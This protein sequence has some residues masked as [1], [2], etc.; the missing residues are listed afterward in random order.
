MVP[1]YFDIVVPRVEIWVLLHLKQ[2]ERFVLANVGHRQSKKNHVI[3]Q[4][5]TTKTAQVIS[6]QISFNPRDI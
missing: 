3:L 5:L 6:G 4:N 1:F 2:A